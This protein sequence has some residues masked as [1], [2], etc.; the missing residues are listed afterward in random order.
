MFIQQ[1][2]SV[3]AC[4]SVKRYSPW[5]KEMKGV[6]AGRFRVGGAR[7]C[8]Y[9][10]RATR[11]FCFYCRGGVTAIAVKLM[12]V[13]EKGRAAERQ[14]LKTRMCLGL[15]SL[16]TLPQP[17]SPCSFYFLLSRFCF[18]LYT[19][20]TSISYLLSISNNTSIRD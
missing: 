1:I 4:H 13:P 16:Q 2:R 10:Y 3:S 5:R 18:L 7:K 11:C 15:F 19:T 12:A 20:P 9:L 14:L 6:T 17:L 8:I